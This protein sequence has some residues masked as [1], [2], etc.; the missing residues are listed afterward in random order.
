MPL[1]FLN[2]KSWGT[3]CDPARAERAMADFVDAVRAAAAA[4]GSGTA[5]VSEVDVKALEIAE[6]YP[7][8]KWIGASP[9]NRAL[10]QRLRGLQGRSPVRSVFPAED[11]ADH[12]EYR[13]DGDIV[14]GLGAAHIMDGIAVSLPVARQWQAD[15]VTVERSELVEYDDSTLQVRHDTVDVRHVSAEPHLE[16]HVDWIRKTRREGVT[17]GLR[18]WDSRADLY[19][20][21]TFLPR[22]KGQLSGLNPHWV[23]PVRRTLERLE[24][25][26]AAWDPATMAEP[27]WPTKVSPEG[28]TRKRVCRFT[29]LDGETRTFDLHARFT[30]GAGRI[31]FRLVPE[32]RAIRLA[33]IGS[34]IRPEL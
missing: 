1:L 33:H 5:L 9:R 24:E 31:H 19:P 29:D 7:V 27:E 32:E 14:L 15:S 26:V 23:L 2:E 22:V 30:P 20:H 18:M 12:L 6:G 11:A 8:N 17:T 3:A 21:L 34:K 10:W 25:A 16:S 4:G 28:E 13:H